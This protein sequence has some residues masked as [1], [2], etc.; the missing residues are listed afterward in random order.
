MPFSMQEFRDYKVA[1]GSLSMW[2]LGQASFF[3]KSPKGIIAAIDPYLS[4]YCA[5]LAEKAGLD[6]RRL[7]PPPI[8]PEELVGIALYV[9]TH[10]HEDHCDPETVEAYRRAGGKG[11]YLAPAETREKLHEMGVPNSQIVMTW[12]NKSYTIG[13]LEFRATFAIP[14][15][16]D[17]MTHVGYL[18][19]VQ[20]GP[21]LYITGDTA[22]HEVLGVTV[23]EYKP[24]VMLTVINGVFRNMGPADAARL[25][26]QV[27]PKVVIPYHYGLF[28]DSPMHPRILKNNL[29][30]Y[31]MKYRYRTLGIA[32]PYIF[33]EI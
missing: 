10:S 7:T 28:Y 2:W 13:D 29:L 6:C 19:S 14:F 22:Y 12:P 30:L 25:A 16:G 1:T 3:L 27:Q 18:V 32:R 15:T 33:P 11:P 5:L 4:D 24:D 23:A 26:N 17:D 21:R 31:G 9:L 8:A 20:N